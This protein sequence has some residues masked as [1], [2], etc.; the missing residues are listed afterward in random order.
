MSPPTAG[1]HPE[2]VTTADRP[3]LDEQGKAVLLPG[4]PEFI[5]HDQVSAELIGRAAEYFPRHDVRLLHDGAVVA[6]GWAVALRWN[7]SNDD[8]PAGY[9]G[10]LISA[11]AEHESGA[12]PDTLCVMAAAVDQPWQGRGLGGQVLTALRTRAAQAGLERM[13][14]PVRPVL[15]SRYPLTPMENYARWTRADG[16]HVDPWIRTHQ[17]LGAT[18]LR[19]AARSMIV[20]G[21]IAQWQDWAGLAFPETGR[22]VVPGALDLVEIDV[23]RDHGAYAE[24]NLW[25]RHA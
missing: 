19:P 4:W 9:D 10:A 22:Y 25:M 13:I 3:D 2:I 24:T 23:E 16:S 18:I 21:T 14:A 17:R 12:R 7:G 15:K 11:I 6:G 5:F 20:T 1:L 8:L